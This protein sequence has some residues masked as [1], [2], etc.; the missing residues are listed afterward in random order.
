MIKGAPFERA[1]YETVFVCIAYIEFLTSAFAQIF[2]F[3]NGCGRA[4]QYNQYYRIL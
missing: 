2:Y 4:R 1:L 3:L